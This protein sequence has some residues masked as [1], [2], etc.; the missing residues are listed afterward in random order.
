[1]ILAEMSRILAK[2]EEISPDEMT[3]FTPELFQ[4]KK[5]NDDHGKR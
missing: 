3:P 4:L 1:M 5:V 2:G